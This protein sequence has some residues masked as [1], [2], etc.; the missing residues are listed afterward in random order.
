[1]TKSL[2]IVESPAKARTIK[3]YLGKNFDVKASVGHV[4]DLPKK[5]LGIEI[6]KEGGF[7]PSY[8]TIRGKGKIISELK[9]A[10]KTAEA[11]Y[12]APD[13]DREG[14]AI[15]W[16]IAHEL[17]RGEGVYRVLFHEITPQAIAEALKNPLAIDEDK[18]NAQQSR[19]IL[20][21]L[22]G[23]KI[24]PLL[25]KTVRR[26]LSAGRV[27][28]VAVRLVCDRE[29]EIQTF[30]PQEYWH[31][32]ANLEG[33]QPPPFAA[34]LHAV[35]GKKAVV[36]NQQEAETIVQQLTSVPFL[37]AKCEQKKRRRN[38]LPPF[39]TSKL[40]Q[41]AARKLNFSAKK[42]M[43]VAQQL[44]EGVDLG[45]AGPTG[46][47]TYMRTDSVRVSDMAL[48]DCRA[49]IKN[50]FGDDYLPA[51]AVHFKNKN[52]AQ[53]A[54]EA[55]R[56][57]SMEHDPERIA[58]F[59]SA[60][61]LKL[62]RLIWNRFAASQMAPAQYF[63][64]IADIQAGER[65]LFRAVGRRQIF[66]GFLALYEEGTDNGNVSEQDTEL[67][68]LAEGDQLNLEKLVPSQ[69]FTQPPP[70]F[71]EST[72]VKE[73]EEQGIGRP[74]TYATILSTIQDRDYVELKEKKFYPTD[75]GELVTQL[76]KKSFPDILDVSFTA[77]LEGKLDLVGE[78][79]QDWQQLLD[80]FYQPFNEKLV[81]AVATMKEVKQQEQTTDEVCEKCG[82]QMVIKWG[83]N[84]KFLACPNY[85]E[86]KNTRNL[87]QKEG[88]EV[89]PATKEELDQLG[90]CPECEQPLTIKSGRFGRFIA[91]S[92]YP[93]CKYTRSI[94]TGIHCP[95][96][97]CD[98][99]IVEKRS[100]KGKI[101]YSCSRYPDCTYALWNKPYPLTCPQCGHPFLVEKTSKSRGHFLQCPEKECSYSADLPDKG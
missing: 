92:R 46:L 39:I 57:T 12:L 75:L 49:Y 38:P 10:A 95:Q 80:D 24:S 48:Q 11:V 78:G 93:E 89:P 66:D 81:A 4:K 85:P 28:S 43:M 87:E 30:K 14:E 60:E 23:Y 32:E 33:R 20:D 69:H 16:H 86:C 73:L 9:K 74:S 84:G 62:Y 37:V 68:P 56:P 42:T 47:I 54:H 64:T 97:G 21:R 90:N 55:I 65:F 13:P 44:Y 59:L 26:G 8:V 25:W 50:R 31:I 83:R 40:Q 51:R 17:G 58:P 91:C 96:D 82:A 99:E 27:Q 36:G 94:G 45:D 6:T 76:L 101:F 29:A 5:E 3:K 34:R 67:P 15:A 79:K 2:L 61:Q 1:M 7:V 63:Q 70:R 19:R 88:P 22:V 100:R 77:Q 41:E 18:V 71:T 53:D 98:G 52:A 35:D 72:L